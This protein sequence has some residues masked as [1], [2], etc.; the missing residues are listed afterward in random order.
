MLPLTPIVF[1]LVLSRNTFF[2][3]IT[4]RCFCFGFGWKWLSPTDRFLLSKQWAGSAA[5]WDA[6]RM[7]IMDWNLSV[8]AR[9]AARR[10]VGCLRVFP[11]STRMAA[12]ARPPGRPAAGASALIHVQFVLAII[13]T[14]KE[15]IDRAT[16][17][18]KNCLCRLIICENVMRVALCSSSPCR[19]RP[20]HVAP[21]ML[22]SGCHCFSWRHFDGDSK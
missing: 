21:S 7:N 18:S 12:G 2:R 19:L 6:R 10:P 5:M 16:L 3:I 15:V 4:S 14:V 20:T 22:H 17:L 8:V 1:I 9:M 11:C 13:A